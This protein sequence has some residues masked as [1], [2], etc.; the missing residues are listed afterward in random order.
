MLFLTFSAGE[1]AERLRREV[2]AARI[3]IGEETVRTAISIGVSTVTSDIQDL[4]ALMISADKALYQA[5]W[6]G[7]NRVCYAKIGS[8]ELR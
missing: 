8:K 5:K 1:A 4:D 7:R 6:Q 3:P 2:S